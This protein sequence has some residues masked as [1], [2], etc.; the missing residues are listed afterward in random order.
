MPTAC[1]HVVLQVQLYYSQLI[2]N[3]N[4][5]T[6]SPNMAPITAHTVQAF[7]EYSK[8]EDNAEPRTQ[9]EKLTY[10][11]TLLIWF[12]DATRSLNCRLIMLSIVCERSIECVGWHIGRGNVWVE[13]IV[14]DGTI[15]HAWNRARRQ[16]KPCK[17][18][19]VRLTV[20]LTICLTL[21]HYVHLT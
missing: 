6:K 19:T 5:C 9:G 14:P 21:C 4:W 15:G 3:N 20:C 2:T 11:Y 18:S 8:R 10:W 17:K 13:C 7:T 1:L 16:Y 12:V